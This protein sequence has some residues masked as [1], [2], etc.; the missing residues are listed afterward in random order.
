MKSSAR[1]ALFV[2][3]VLFAAVE[4]K[5]QEGSA[6][7][8]RV[9]TSSVAQQQQT[10]VAPVVQQAKPVELAPNLPVV[11]G[12]QQNKTA[13]APINFLTPSVIKTRITDAQLAELRAHTDDIDF[14]RAAFHERRLRHDVMAHIHAYGEAAP[15]AR[16]VLHL[17]NLVEL[18]EVGKS[19][20]QGQG[21]A[22]FLRPYLEP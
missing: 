21:I 19:E 13:A 6:V 20:H 5:A 22:T 7:R 2:V 4:L 11:D 17:G 16:A 15:S 1:L 8:P 9:V 12:E 14:A 10:T 18:L 3:A